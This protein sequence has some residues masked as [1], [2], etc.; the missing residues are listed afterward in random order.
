MTAAALPWLLVAVYDVLN[1][2]LLSNLGKMFAA[3]N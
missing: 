2:T 1:V 3:L